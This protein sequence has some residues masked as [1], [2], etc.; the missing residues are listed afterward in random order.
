MG[1]LDDGVGRRAEG[2]LV[3][4]KSASPPI[5]KAG[6]SWI[7]RHVVV[8]RKREKERKEKA[9]EDVGGVR[10]RAWWLWDTKHKGVSM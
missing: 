1:G 6:R 7:S 4:G 10:K 9:K 2:Q 5:G 8:V 3:T